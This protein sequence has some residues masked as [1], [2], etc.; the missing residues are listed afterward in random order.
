[1]IGRERFDA[2]ADRAHRKITLF[3]AMVDAELI[4]PFQ[5]YVYYPII[6]AITAYLT[7][8]AVAVPQA[9]EANLSGLYLDGWLALGLIC[10]PMSL[11][12]RQFYE[13]AREKMPNGGYGGALLMLFG[14]LGVWSAIIIYV[15]CTADTFWWG[16]GLWAVGFV[17]M[18]VPGGAIFTYRSLRRLRQIRHRERRMP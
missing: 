18:G 5:K 8:G 12:G 7:F 9:V 15:Q 4:V 3:N 14:D 6:T 1:M 11:A 17:L 2:W 13:R 16:Q 10:P